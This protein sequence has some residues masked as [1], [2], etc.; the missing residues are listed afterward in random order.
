MCNLSIF[1]A[2]SATSLF[3]LTSLLS[4]AEPWRS[5]L[6]PQDWTPGLKDS[7]GRFLQDF[8]YAGY[9]Q[10][11]VPIPEI[12]GPIY[13]VVEDF[14][15]D[16]TGESDSTPAIQAAIDAAASNGGGV[17]YLPEG[18]YFSKSG[19]EISESG[20]VLRGAGPGATRL[21]FAD[22]E[23]KKRAHIKI[24]GFENV[25]LET[26]LVEDGAQLSNIIA[27]ED[28][29]GFEVG[30]DVDLG[31][32]ITD[33]FIEEHGMAGIWKPHNGKW[34]PFFRVNIVSIDLE[35]SPNLVEL[36]VPLRYIA[37][38]RDAAMIRRRTNYIE[39]CGV[40]NLSLANPVFEGTVDDYSKNIQRWLI[41]FRDAKNC[42]V[43]NV[44][45]Y[46]PE[47]EGYG[48]TYQ[49]YDKGIEIIRSKRITI[50][51]V[52]IGA[53]Q[54]RDA[55]PGGHGY[56]FNLL[57]SNDIL[58]KDSKGVGGR[59]AF[60]SGWYFG[61]VGN[62]FLR[63]ISRDGS[64]SDWNNNLGP[65]DFHH[66]LAMA[67]LIDSCTIDDGW[68]AMNRGKMSGGA[69]HTATESVFWN[70]D[71]HGIIRSAQ[72]RWGYLIGMSDSLEVVTE[73][74]LRNPNWIGKQFIGTE[75]FDYVENKG[76]QSDL[77]P[78]SLYE[79]QL[80]RRLQSAGQ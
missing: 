41:Q 31:W 6:Y 15:A 42:W 66:S 70:C 26:P 27:V 32:V 3:L 48:P 11:E 69:G 1:S 51:H 34:M 76:P 25:M 10:G 23:S 46:T 62:V 8:S 59:H 56:L 22:F 14:G 47:G 9:Q 5:D 20:I 40:E 30:D 80:E 28:A 61:N 39:E 36:D 78:Q 58:I 53:A 12:E 50:D 16:S 33:P 2:L 7:D 64:L 57:G 49:L 24:S 37:K 55:G 75:P 38:V 67:N 73:V 63:S 71:G 18:D 44:S 54:R 17:V 21:L 19:L 68:E 65:S 13:D 74:D 52:E 45:T 77:V 72:Y 35:S 60:I 4:Q 29:S 79:S 43:S